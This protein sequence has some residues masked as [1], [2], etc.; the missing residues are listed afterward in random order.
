LIT[1]RRAEAFL[2]QT[3]TAGEATPKQA[4]GPNAVES[5]AKAK[6]PEVKLPGIGK[7]RRMPI[8]VKCR[9]TYKGRRSGKPG[10]TPQ[11]L[12]RKIKT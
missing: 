10:G 3:E 8:V 12:K 1:T 2:E 6:K 4:K 5:F 9:R 7:E 11:G